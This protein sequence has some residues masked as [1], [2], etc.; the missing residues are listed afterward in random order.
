MNDS[1]RVQIL[2]APKNSKRDEDNFSLGESLS[3]SQHFVQT[4]GG[5]ELENYINVVSVFKE[6]LELDNVLMANR[7]VY[8]D[9]RHEFLSCS[10]LLKRLLFDHFP[11]YDF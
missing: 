4:V 9:L 1:V 8:F 5:T 10:G 7:S 2:D 11:S 3:S 6:V